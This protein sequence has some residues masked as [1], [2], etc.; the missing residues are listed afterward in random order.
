MRTHCQ[1]HPSAEPALAGT[2][3]LRRAESQ[4][5]RQCRR[6][7]YWAR[8]SSI[9]PNWATWGVRNWNSRW[10]RAAGARLR[11]AWIRAALE[12]SRARWNLLSG[13]KTGGTET[14]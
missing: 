12:A 11:Q 4:N 1:G 8:D 14:P 13:Q 10:V 5:E 7:R 6:P 2:S 3:A 9:T